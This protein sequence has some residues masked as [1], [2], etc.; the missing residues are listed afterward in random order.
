MHR[1]YS[2]GEFPL[3]L[4]GSAVL[5]LDPLKQKNRAQKCDQRACQEHDKKQI[6]KVLAVQS[7]Y[8]VPGGGGAPYGMI[9][10]YGAF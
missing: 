2:G 10:L 9:S 1:R 4:P 5:L 7:C 8:V 6:T 3:M